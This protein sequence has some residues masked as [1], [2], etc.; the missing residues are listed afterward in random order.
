[1]GSQLSFWQRLAL[2]AGVTLGL[3]ALAAIMV[4]GGLTLRGNDVSLSARF[5]Q[6][7]GLEPGSRVRLLGIDI[8]TIES[9]YLEGDG[10]RVTMRIR[11]HHAANLL[12]DTEAR[13]VSEGLVGG[14]VLELRPGRTGDPV[15][16]GSE[17]KGLPVVDW[18]DRLEQLSSSGPDLAIK[19]DQSLQG[20]AR[21]SNAAE[22]TLKRIN[23]GE[24]SL[25]RLS[26]DERLY[27]ELV[28]LT[29][30]GK[31]TLDSLQRDAEA[32][33]GVPGFSSLVRDPGKLLIRPDCQARQ[34]WFPEGDLF[35]T[36]RAVLS[37]AGQMRLNTPGR[38]IAAIKAGNSEV[39][40][41]SY[42][43]GR[44]TADEEA[45]RVLTEKQSQMVADY[46]RKHHGINKTGWISW[47]KVSALGMG[48]AS[49]PAKAIPPGPAPRTEIWLFIPS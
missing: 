38:E 29:Q 43:T 1:M 7:R 31:R 45:A 34:W 37:E 4:N 26:R 25:G 41:V 46:L 14:K 5:N 2:V 3:I 33:Q 32:L 48:W 30:R 23:Q 28:E 9:L 17:I 36:G 40:V 11:A 44:G 24:G 8:G 20:L 47:R 18:E 13:I 42:A 10:V 21:L 6:V 16:Q 12:S 39:V 15:A 27:E 35:E 49:P 19:L 22:E